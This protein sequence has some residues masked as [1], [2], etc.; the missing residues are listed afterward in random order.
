MARLAPNRLTLLLDVRGGVATILY[1]N[2]V[3][4]WP[5]PFIMKPVPS[6]N[7]P[8]VELEQL[9]CRNDIWRGRSRRLV[10]PVVLDSGY[11]A[12]NR[13][14]TG[15]GWPMGEL[16]EICQ[17]G[18]VQSEWLLLM[19]ALLKTH[20]GLLVLLNP[21]YV[22]FAQT[23]ITAGIDLE[24][25]IVVE[26]TEKS[27]FLASYIELTRSGSCDAVLAWEPGQS[28]SYTELRKCLLASTEGPGLHVLF[29]PARVRVQ[30]S[31]A[32][33]RLHINLEADALRVGIFKQKGELGV[34]AKPVLLPLPLEWK[35]FAPHRQL[36]QTGKALPEVA[37]VMP[38]HGGW[39]GRK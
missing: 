20:R 26:N 21:P 22:P 10:P 27:D 12:L 6:D 13:T 28:L 4:K 31:P 35:G 7:P 38:L 37:N 25:V 15:G 30:S 9:L 1:I 34:P 33:L 29:R 3:I 2:T 19:P 23:L 8:A 36:D 16:I 5:S 11:V 14:L 32:S 18:L 24:R 39:R 17:Q